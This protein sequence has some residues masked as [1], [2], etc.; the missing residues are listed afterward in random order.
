MFSQ[1]NNPYY[2]LIQLYGGKDT[3]KINTIIYFVILY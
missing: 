2:E 3:K 1:R